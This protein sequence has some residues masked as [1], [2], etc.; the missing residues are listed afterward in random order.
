MLK[1]GAPL[2]LT[3]PEYCLWL[4]GIPLWILA[5]GTLVMVVIVLLCFGAMTIA[6]YKRMSKCVCHKKEK[7]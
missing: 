5:I 3:L 2:T 1:E 4:I 6:D 7:P